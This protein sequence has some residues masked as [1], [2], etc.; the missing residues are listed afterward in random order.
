MSILKITPLL[1]LLVIIF[2]CTERSPEP[3]NL[4]DAVAQHIEAREFEEA[5][6]QLNSA[7]DRAG[8]DGA[9]G[10]DP[11][12]ITRLRAEAHLAYANYLTHEADHLAMGER[13]SDALRHYRR[14][15]ELDQNNS[16]AQTHVELIE[17][18]Y[19]Q[20]DRDIPVGVAE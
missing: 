15:L 17:S 18:I 13:M 1:L 4:Q 3:G 12:Q 2:G 10:P 7:E 20:M 9:E 14:V 11:Q 5:F 19:R 6:E 8:R 16:Q